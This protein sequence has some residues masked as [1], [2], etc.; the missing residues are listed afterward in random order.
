MVTPDA[1]ATIHFF[2]TEEG[3][4]CEATPANYFGTI[5]EYEGEFWDCRLLL[6][7]VGSISPGQTVT[8]PI[9]FLSPGVIKPLLR[10]GGRFRVRE[11]RTIADGTIERIYL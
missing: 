3:G 6:E 4:R 11:M 8:V 1:L 5:L 9:R 10:V 2:P 7:D